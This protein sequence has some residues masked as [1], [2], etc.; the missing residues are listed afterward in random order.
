MNMSLYLPIFE[1]LGHET[2]LKVFDFIYQSGNVGVRPKDM[3]ERF[4]IDSGT[5]DFHLK[6]LV[7]V[8]LISLKIG[9]LRGVYCS[10][11]NL[12]IEL[13]RLLDAAFAGRGAI[14]H[15]AIPSTVSKLES[16]H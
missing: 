2:R 7:G 11:P 8:G 3:I 16:L 4:S 14:M 1:A 15:N 6:K 12:P 10:S 5:L 13:T 9:S